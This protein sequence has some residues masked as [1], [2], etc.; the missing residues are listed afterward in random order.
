SP[1]KDNIYAIWHNGNPAFVNRRTGP[2]GSWGTAFQISGAES[3][4]TSIGADIKTNSFGDVFAFWP[5]TGYRKV[6]VKKSTNGGTSFG[7]AIQIGTTIDSFEVG[8]PSFNSRKAL[9]Y[10]TAG[11]YRTSGKDLVY[12]AWN[13]LSGET[14]CTSG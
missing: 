7:A 8:V 3:T 14:G 10:V 5:A 12:A 13:D 2:G 4:G 11:A 1:F 9:I 6:F